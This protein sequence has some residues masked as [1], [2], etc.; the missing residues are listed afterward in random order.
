MIMESKKKVL[1]C[2]WVAQQHFAERSNLIG[3]L[4]TQ[5]WKQTVKRVEAM[6]LRP[7]PRQHDNVVTE[8][9]L[10]NARDS[11]VLGS[12]LVNNL[13]HFQISH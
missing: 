11:G 6:H 10:V 9:F 1:L 13:V 2:L 3:S 5:G 7:V 12:L 4:G 8:V